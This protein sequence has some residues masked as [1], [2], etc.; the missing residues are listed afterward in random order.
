M[1]SR[2][3]HLKKTRVCSRNVAIYITRDYVVRQTKNLALI[4]YVLICFTSM[5]NRNLFY[6]ILEHFVKHLGR[7][8]LCHKCK[9][10]R[11]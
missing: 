7:W 8:L 11:P 3:H 2:P 5:N 4:I 1:T 6:E 9:T 10:F